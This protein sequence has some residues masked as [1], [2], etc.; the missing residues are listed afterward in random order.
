MPYLSCCPSPFV[1]FLTPFLFSLFLAC[2]FYYPFLSFLIS[3]FLSYCHTHS[4]FP[5]FLSC[6]H[7][8]PFP[9]FLPYLS[10]HTYTHTHTLPHTLLGI[11]CPTIHSHN[12]P[13]SFLLSIF[14]FLSCYHTYIIPFLLFLPCLSSHT[15]VPSFHPFHSFSC[16][17]TH[18]PNSFFYKHKENKKQKTKIT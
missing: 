18:T 9:F 8:H 15:H 12:L 5:S 2:L 1:L 16:C 6:C 11:A 10:S 14:L 4:I 17:H 3:T 13:L 7:T